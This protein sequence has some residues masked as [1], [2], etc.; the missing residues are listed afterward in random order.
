MGSPLPVF[1][2]W[3]QHWAHCGLDF[4]W[5]GKTA[6]PEFWDNTH[7]DW[8][9]T[10]DTG[11]RKPIAPCQFLN[12]H[13]MTSHHIVGEKSTTVRIFTLPKWTKAR[14]RASPNAFNP[15]NWSLSTDSTLLKRKPPWQVQNKQSSNK[16]QG[17]WEEKKISPDWSGQEALY[18]QDSTR[19]DGSNG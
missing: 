19:A 6:K 7:N 11:G 15:E 12:P 13:S 1:P 10:T 9:P 2:I 4:S 3:S 16:C 17:K 14:N 18:L 8:L 5:E